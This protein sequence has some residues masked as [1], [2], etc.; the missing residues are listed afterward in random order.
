LKL[1]IINQYASKPD[2]AGLTRHYELARR[3]TVGGIETLVVHGSFD[4]YLKNRHWSDH[5]STEKKAVMSQFDGVYFL[6]I[7]TPPYRNNRSIGRIHSMFA[8]R[9]RAY[10]EMMSGRHGKPDVVMGSTMT[11]FG[12]DAARRL[13]AR[14]SVPFIYEVR[15][16]WPL[17]PIEIGGHSKW[18]PFLLYLDY[19][20]GEMAK[21]ADLVITTAPLMKEY[22]KERFGL[23][24]E[25]FLWITNG[26]DLELF[27]SSDYALE[28][29]KTTFDLYYTGS[30]GLANGLDKIFD[31]L[32]PVQKKF[33]QFRLV[34]VGDGPLRQHL[35]ERAFSEGLPVKFMDPVPK[36]ELPAVLSKADACLIYLKPSK[37]YRFGIS[38]NKLADYHAAAKPVL[39]VGDCTENPVTRAGSGIVAEGIDHFPDALEEM[40]ACRPEKRKE[41]GAKA[42]AFAE[43]HYDWDKLADKLATHLTQICAHR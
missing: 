16:L 38:A 19:L 5:I 35:K 40:I 41:M 9:G 22:H 24:D 36:T 11:L 13:A 31:Q 3:L 25:K 21:A 42:R 1:W 10:K 15:D 39:F 27:K 30:L 32:P 14:F 28:S 18:H 33:P 23:P 43:E 7:P 8:F 2:V 26:T 37:L 6:T 4:L 17:T 12:A 34:L 20:D 29:E